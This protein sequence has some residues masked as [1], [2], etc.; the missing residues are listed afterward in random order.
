[1]EVVKE[2]IVRRMPE[3]R[4]RQYG[5]HIKQ[6]FDIYYPEDF[7]PGA[8]EPLPMYVFVHGGGWGA[9]D[10][11]NRKMGNPGG[12][13][14]KLN[15]NGI[16][17]VSIG[18]MLHERMLELGIESYFWAGDSSKEEGRVHASDP[19]YDGWSGEMNFILD[20]FGMSEAP[21]S[22]YPPQCIWGSRDGCPGKWLGAL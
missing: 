7:D 5:K 22:E 11:I 20:Q 19:R 4:S 13:A 21:G 8:D 16:A 2:N 17:L 14:D 18:K 12:L 3:V 15:E 10:K 9:G 1:M 6:S